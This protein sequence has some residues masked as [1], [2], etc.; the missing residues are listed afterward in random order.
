MLRRLLILSLMILLAALLPLKLFAQNGSTER[1]GAEVLAMP[2]DD[3]KFR[4]LETMIRAQT[5]PDTASFYI[6]HQIALSNRIGN[7]MFL[8]RALMNKA[9]TYGRLHDYDNAIITYAKALKAAEEACDRKSMAICYNEMAVMLTRTNDYNK[10]TECFNNALHI[11]VEIGDTLKITDVY[12]NMGRQCLSFH[13]YKTAKSYFDNAFALDSISGDAQSLGLDFYNVGKS[14]YLQFLDLD[15]TRLLYSGINKVKCSLP[16]FI[17]TGNKRLIQ[18]CYEQLMLMYVSIYTIGDPKLFKLARD[19]A[20]YYYNLTNKLRTELTPNSEH[21]VLEITNAN[22]LTM[23]GKHDDAIKILKNLEKKFDEKGAKYAR[24]RAFLYRSMIWSLCEAGDYKG[25]VEY[26]EK[27]K[28]A[29]ESTY[30]REF[31]VKSIKASAETEYSEII[32][33]REASDRQ[34]EQLQR[35]QIKKQRTITIFFVISIVLAAILVVAIWESLKRKRRNNEVLAQQ[36]AEILQKNNELQ[37]QNQKIESQRD[38]ILAQRDEI[39]AQKTQLADANSRITASIRYAQ[40]IQAASVP[41]AEM[42]QKIFGEFMVYWKPLNIVSGDFFWATQAGRYKLLTA[43]DCSGHGVPGAFMSML[44]VST[45]NDIAA[46]KDIEGTEMTAASVLEELRTKIIDALRQSGPQ[47]E[48]QDGIEMAFCI[49]DAQKQEVQYSGANRPLWLVRNGALTEY[50]PDN[51]HVGCHE[52]D[53]VPFTNT[54]IS[55]QKGD[56]IYMGSDGIADQYGGGE[57]KPRFGA[58]RLRDLLESIA[59]KPFSEQHS[60]IETT[61]SDWQRRPN[62]KHEPQIG[63]QILVG[64]R[65]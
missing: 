48:T 40:R 15:S 39:E 26:S 38:E 53:N 65:I 6:E 32:R 10:A 12:R 34:E 58:Q 31:A 54:I 25:A 52:K 61:L 21:T 14:D 55:V 35:E 59:A 23:D 63:D 27:F 9:Y 5:N 46:Q 18:G 7:R 19:S 36:K 60:L 1:R 56:T 17:K 47:R 51:M 8:T 37:A 24:Y 33:K 2:D 42:M 30:N 50:K 41:S 22:L 43:A 64:I 11:Y 3:N 44:G 20:R 29:E 13:L 16:F 49:I 45:L 28:V 62:G 57:G 4:A